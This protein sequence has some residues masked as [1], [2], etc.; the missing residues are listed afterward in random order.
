RG[1]PVHRLRRSASRISRFSLKEFPCMPGALDH[2]ES[3]RRQA[4]AASVVLPS[5]PS[6]CV[7]T[8][9]FRSFSRLN[10]LPACTPVNASALPLRGQPHDSGPEW[11]AH[12][13][14]YGSFIHYSLPI[15][16]GAFRSRSSLPLGSLALFSARAKKEAVRPPEREALCTA[17]RDLQ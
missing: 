9:V 3:T 2:A 11:A 5:A 8:R 6:D 17:G 14:P 12:P 1:P 7:G 13:S 16:I 10:T 15:L 4:I